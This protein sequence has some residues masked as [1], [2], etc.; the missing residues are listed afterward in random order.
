MPPLSMAPLSGK[1][2]L[3]PP[4]DFLL[5]NSMFWLIL[6]LQSVASCQTPKI[7]LVMRGISW[8]EV[9]AVFV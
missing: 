4:K 7:I 2:D 8:M 3:G 1:K 5:K 6:G 9:L